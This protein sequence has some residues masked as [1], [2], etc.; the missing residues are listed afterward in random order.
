MTGPR[1]RRQIVQQR[2]LS[3]LLR[4]GR[5][6]RELPVVDVLASTGAGDN[7]NVAAIPS[8]NGTLTAALNA[9]TFRILK[10]SKNPDAAFTVLAYLL[11][12][13][14]GAADHGLR[15]HARP[16]RRAGRLLQPARRHSDAARS[17]RRLAGRQGRH[18]ARRHPQLRVATARIQPSHCNDPQHDSTY[19]SRW[20][21]TPGLDMD[22]QID[23]LQR[24][25]QAIWDAELALTT[26]PSSSVRSDDRS[27]ARVLARSAQS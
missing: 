9:D 25:L 20:D 27:A 23:A 16:K 15:R 1:S 13:A 14:A 7:W 21:T 3:F 22:P 19:A 8:Y 6:G 10:D 5:H 26:R 2:R 12:H 24:E 18:P 4:Q 11:G 17:R